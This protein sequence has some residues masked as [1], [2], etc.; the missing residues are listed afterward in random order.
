MN[1]VQFS[2][3]ISDGGQVEQTVVVQR[4]NCASVVGGI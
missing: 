2:G 4:G 1:S 3:Y